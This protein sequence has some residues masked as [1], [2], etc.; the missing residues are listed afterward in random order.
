MSMKKCSCLLSKISNMRLDKLH[1]ISVA[2]QEIC[3]GE[4]PWVALGNFLNYWWDYAK[5]RRYALVADPLP[6]SPPEYQ[7]WAAYC[8]ASVEHLCHKYGEPCPQWVY[9]PKYV[10]PEPW[11]Y[12]PKEKVRNWLITTTPDE[13][14]KRN[15]YSGNR[16]FLNKYELAEQHAHHIKPDRE[17]MVVEREGPINQQLAR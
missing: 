10:L 9:D 11:Y 17:T 4:D 8:A 14:K 1:T 13:F 16:M 6:E 15:I 12:H 7:R 3:A 2:F 5:E